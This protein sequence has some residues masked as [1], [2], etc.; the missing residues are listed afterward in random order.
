MLSLRSPFL[1]A[2]SPTSEVPVYEG[3]SRGI[4]SLLRGLTK[5]DDLKILP[6]RLDAYP[7][8]LD[9]YFQRMF[10]RMD[11]VYSTKSSLLMLVALSAEK[12]LS[13]WAPRR[14]E[15]ETEVPDHALGLRIPPATRDASLFYGCDCSR[16]EFNSA[17]GALEGIATVQDI[18]D[19]D[20][21]MPAAP[22][23]LEIV[24]DGVTFVHR[25]ARDFL[26]VG[27]LSVKL[28]TQ[29]GEDFDVG[30]SLARLS[31]VDAKRKAGALCR[32]SDEELRWDELRGL[33]HQ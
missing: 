19:S 1:A 21:T 24:P 29:A 27:N 26:E 6:R 32:F 2:L 18:V 25:T 30:L 5:A 14:L 7:N 3:G 15:V 31:V 11:N 17:T 28:H 33:R 8:T 22:T 23:L 16:T 12:V 4:R 10:D 9:E 13:F 20:N